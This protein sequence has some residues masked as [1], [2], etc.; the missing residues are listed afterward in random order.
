MKIFV[1]AEKELFNVNQIERIEEYGELV[2]LNK[3]TYIADITSDDNEKVVVYDPDFGG[4]KFP[5]EI[6]EKSNNLKSVFLGTTD[7][8]YIDLDY[9]ESMNI[10]VYSIPRYATDSVAE[11][12][13][14]YMFCLAR[15]IPLQIKNNNS[16]V[17]T[18]NYEQMELRG[19]KVGI[20]GLGNI[21]GRIA[22][23]CSGI[24]MN[25]CYWNRTKKD[26]NYTYLSLEELFS[27][28]DVVFVCLAINDETQIIITDELLN[29]LKKNS[30]FIS[31]TGKSLFNNSIIEERVKNN[32]LF[33]YALEEPNKPLNDYEGNVMVTSEYAW[34]TKEASEARMN[35]WTEIIVDKM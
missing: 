5:K 27:T 22:N 32:E 26:A 2:F 28:C 34:F 31:C 14:M 16:Q 33:G 9:C 24:G 25:V 20:V 12:L 3:D 15:K 11:Y 1:V 17:F 29:K 4:W 7:K 10:N 30:I 13:V 18:S 35:L 21:G 6:L 23:I 19:K 8:S